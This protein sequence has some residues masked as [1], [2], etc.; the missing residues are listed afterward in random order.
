MVSGPSSSTGVACREIFIVHA[1]D[2]ADTRFVHEVLVPS[3]RLPPESVSLSSALPPG[4]TVV[5]AVE[6]ALLTSRIAVLVLSPSFLRETWASFGELLASH[7]AVSGQGLLVP[8]VI[9]DC[10]LPPRLE[11]WVRLDLRAEAQRHTELARLRRL[12]RDEVPAP[13]ARGERA[14]LRS[15]RATPIHLR[16][17]ARFGVAF[18]ICA[19]AALHFGAPRLLGISSAHGTA[20]SDITINIPPK[21]SS[22][23]SRVDDEPRVSTSPPIEPPEPSPIPKPSRLSPRTAPFPRK[24]PAHSPEPSQAAPRTPA[25]APTLAPLDRAQRALAHGAHHQALALARPLLRDPTLAAEAAWI[26]AQASCHLARPDDAAR[27]AAGPARAAPGLPGTHLGHRLRARPHHRGRRPRL[28]RGL[29]GGEAPPA[30]GAPL[31]RPHRRYPVSGVL[32]SAE[33]RE[34]GS[35]DVDERSILRLLRR[36]FVPWSVAILSTGEYREQALFSCLKETYRRPPSSRRTALRRILP[37]H[38]A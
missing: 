17:R 35:P 34:D 15:P 21:Q 10:E 23:A 36:L 30:L 5:A 11:M 20:Y 12:L 29:P 27:Y 9:S 38:H 37:L 6:H 26:C 1:S 8:L 28:L 25:T 13:I 31:R 32:S 22:S 33:P 19:L 24:T 14:R 4:R 7:H 16:F 3:L 2:E 18:L